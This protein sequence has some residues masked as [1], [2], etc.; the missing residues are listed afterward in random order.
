MHLKIH[1]VDVKNHEQWSEM[2]VGDALVTAVT[3]HH[4]SS[5][6]EPTSLFWSGR[7]GA[8]EGSRKDQG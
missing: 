7:P 5:C 8:I 4:D 2:I 3:A 1:N 6:C